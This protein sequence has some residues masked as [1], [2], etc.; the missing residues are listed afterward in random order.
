[1][2]SQALIW[3]E[4]WRSFEI[5]LNGQLAYASSWQF[6]LNRGSC[7]ISCKPPA[8]MR[9]SLRRFLRNVRLFTTFK[10]PGRCRWKEKKV[11]Y[12]EASMLSKVASAKKQCLVFQ[13]RKYW[14]SLARVA[15]FSDKLIRIS[16]DFPVAEYH[17]ISTVNDSTSHDDKDSSNASHAS[18][19]AVHRSTRTDQSDKKEDNN[20]ENSDRV[21]RLFCKKQSDLLEHDIRTGD[22]QPLKQPPHRMLP[23][24]RLVIDEQLDELL[25]PGRIER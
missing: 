6:S 14:M 18:Y 21:W 23:Y 11:L 7:T 24:Q 4:I 15:N 22:C 25:A 5:Q 13:S 20:L 8:A 17:P 19:S 9:G 10:V 1:M 2:R 12:T 16:S 3:Q